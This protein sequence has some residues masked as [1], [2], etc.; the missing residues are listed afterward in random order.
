M[1]CVREAQST[2]RETA[3]AVAR[4]VLELGAAGLALGRE[5]LRIH[6]QHDL[7]ALSLATADGRRVGLALARGE[8]QPP[9][10]AR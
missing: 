2:P 7:I 1:I 9:S 6:V 3:A 5:R 4:P 10:P 8:T